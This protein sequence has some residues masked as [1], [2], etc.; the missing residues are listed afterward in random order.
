MK[1]FGQKK[2]KSNLG[3]HNSDKCG[4]EVYNTEG[5]NKSKSRERSLIKIEIQSQHEDANHPVLQVD[6]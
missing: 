2:K 3:I 4:C 6:E 1:P 5:W